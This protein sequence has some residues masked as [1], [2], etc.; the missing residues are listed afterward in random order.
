[1]VRAPLVRLA[2]LHQLAVVVR[3]RSVPRLQLVV[4]IRSVVEVEEGRIRSVRLRGPIH[5]PTTLALSLNNNNPVVLVPHQIA[6]A[7]NKSFLAVENLFV[8]P[9]VRPDVREKSFFS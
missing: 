8:A 7:H 9:N 6:I 4:R 2:R 1:M 3:I 5:L